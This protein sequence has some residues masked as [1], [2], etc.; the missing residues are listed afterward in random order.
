[1]KVLVFLQGT[2]LVESNVVGSTREESVRKFRERAVKKG[3]LGEL[4]PI[5]HSPAKIASWKNRGSEIIYMTASRK[6]ENVLKK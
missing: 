1:V 5:G 4:I 2:V 6:A 3:S